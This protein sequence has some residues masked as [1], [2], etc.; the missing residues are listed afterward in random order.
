MFSLVFFISMRVVNPGDPIESIII[1]ENIVPSV[2]A[3]TYPMD[4]IVNILDKHGEKCL[5]I[6]DDLDGPVSNDV[7]LR[8]IKDLTL[9]NCHILFTARPNAVAGIE[10][11]FTTVCNVE[12]FSENNASEYVKRLLTDAAKVEA[13]MTFTKENQS[14]GIHEMW[15]YPILLLFICILVN[16][17][18]LDLQSKTI[19]LTNIYDRLLLCLFRR[20][21]VKW[22]IKQDPRKR[23]EILLK[24][25]K[26]ALEGLEKGKLFYSKSEIEEKVG[27][28]AFH[29]GIIIGYKDRCIVEDINADFLVCFLHHTICEYLAALYITDQLAHT[30]R[31]PEDIWPKVWATETITQLPLLFIFA[32][33]LCMSEQ[34]ATDKLFKSTVTIFNQSTLELQGNLLGVS[35]LD[36]LF[37]VLD[38]CNHMKVLT[39]SRSRLCDNQETICTILEHIP[40]S[41]ETLVFRE[42]VFVVGETTKPDR[43]PHLKDNTSLDVRCIDC[44][45]PVT[46]LNILAKNKCVHTLLLNIYHVMYS[47]DAQKVAKFHT[48]F[49]DLL[50]C[51]LQNIQNLKITGEMTQPQSISKIAAMH[52]ESIESILNIHNPT[53]DAEFP[54]FAGNLGGLESLYISCGYIP[55]ALLSLLLASIGDR[56]HLR[57]IY[58]YGGVGSTVQMEKTFS[59]QLL[60]KRSPA[61]C[62]VTWNNT[63]DSTFNPFFKAVAQI[64]MKVQYTHYT[65]EGFSEQISKHSAQ[66]KIKYQKIAL[67]H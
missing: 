59:Q 19:T 38:R 14:I 6:F 12:G 20:Y 8:V 37:R 34:I 36:F 22:N 54:S 28:E 42:C 58:I 45:I 63:A 52:K 46:S 62:E 39:F 60:S 55:D 43:M 65:T 40:F 21:T 41:L 4:K 1:D 23:R 67:A 2:Y 3:K 61:L 25:G 56:A 10:G 47:C 53:N 24:L 15:R 11:Y 57:S 49:V 51:S 50:L 30:D 35:T 27:K 17:G 64:G 32:V 18:N 26:V 44:D 31:C 7:V 29:Y 48:A 9:T 5:L 13:V 33:D 66:G 16:D